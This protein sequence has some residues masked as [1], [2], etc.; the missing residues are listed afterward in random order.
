M[1]F[2]FVGIPA[3]EFSSRTSQLLE[4]MFEAHQ[5]DHWI[6]GHFHRDWVH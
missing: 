2:E 4:R 3:D 6:F 1:L 5:P